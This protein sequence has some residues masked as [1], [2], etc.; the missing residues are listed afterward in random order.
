MTFQPKLIR[1]IDLGGA[2]ADNYRRTRQELLLA[3]DRLTRRMKEAEPVRTMEQIEA[4]LALESDRK[5]I[6][7]M[8]SSCSYIIEWLE[9]G[10]RPGNRRGVER[11][12]SYQR[13][14]PTD[15]ARLPAGESRDEYDLGEAEPEAADIRSRRLESAM[16]GLSERERDCFS[17]ARG[18]G[19]SLSE[20]AELLQIS[21]SSAGTYTL[22]A[23]RKIAANV[24]KPA[25]LV[26]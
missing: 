6:V 12:A 8:I 7:E 4:V 22:R 21:K 13:E 16:R 14:I 18:N 10:R 17:L 9:T 20:I 11:L 26:G 25:D 23:Q 5:T 1:T 2:T 15:P 24:G 3:A 19:R